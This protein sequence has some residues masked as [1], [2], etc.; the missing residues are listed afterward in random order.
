MKELEAMGEPVPFGI[1]T[2]PLA[3]GQVAKLVGAHGLTLERYE[4]FGK[5]SANR[6]PFGGLAVAVS[7]ST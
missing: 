3:G 5:E 7:A 6:K 2:D 1:P 4:P